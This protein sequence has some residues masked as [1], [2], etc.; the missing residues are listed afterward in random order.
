MH[1]RRGAHA[2][3]PSHTS[4]DTARHAPARIARRLAFVVVRRRVDDDGGAILVEQR[5]FAALERHVG[6]VD[7]GAQISV[8]VCELVG[9]VARM[10]SM[11]VHEAVVLGQR[12]EMSARA[13]ELY[14]GIALAD[15]MDMHRMGAGFETCASNS[16]STP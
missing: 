12:R 13:V 8:R 7:G 16:I 9:H 6:V 1:V 11:L 4:Y 2:V 3:Q 14:L 10:C 5:A 15:G